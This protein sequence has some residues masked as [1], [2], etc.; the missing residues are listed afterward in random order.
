MTTCCW[1]IVFRPFSNFLDPPLTSHTDVTIRK[2]RNALWGTI[3]LPP[4]PFPAIACH[5]M[6]HA[7]LYVPWQLGYSFIHRFHAG[8]SR[9]Q[10]RRQ[11]SNIHAI[12]LNIDIKTSKLTDRVVHMNETPYPSAPYHTVSHPLQII[13]PSTFRYVISELVTCVSAML[14]RSVRR[15]I[16]LIVRDQTDM[17]VAVSDSSIIIFVRK[18][19][20]WQW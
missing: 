12:Q 17:A 14:C 4:L 15:S 10:I 16:L 5:K 19:V 2:L 1:Y 11:L 9:V 8:H 20:S 6:S 7:I 13:T 18:L 3:S